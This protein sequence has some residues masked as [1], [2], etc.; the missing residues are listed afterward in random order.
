MVV[1]GGVGGAD[2]CRGDYV[3][4]EKGEN[5]V[6]GAVGVV[7]VEGEEDQGR[8]G[9]GGVGEEW[10]EEGVGPFAGSG[11]GGVV[12]VVGCGGVRKD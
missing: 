7:F 3:A 5:P 11:N 1:E 9:E 4:K 6:L 12:A 8:F 10:G 2:L